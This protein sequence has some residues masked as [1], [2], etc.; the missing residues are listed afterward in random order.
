[1][2]SVLPTDA[3]Y[4]PTP[5]DINFCFPYLAQSLE[6]PQIKLVPFIPRLHA[7]TFF[8]HAREHP[9]DFKHMRFPVPNTLEEMLTW[10]EYNIRRNPENMVFAIMFA[11]EHRQNWSYGAILSLTH[12][13]PERLFAE[14]A[15]GIGFRSHTGRNGAAIGTSLLIRYCMNSPTDSPPG[16]GLRKLGW[17]CHAG[18]FP[19]Q[20]LARSVGFRFESM[21]RWNRTAPSGKE[22]NRR[23]LRK[24]DPLGVPGIDDFYFVLSWDDWEADGRNIV[25]SALS[26][27]FT[28]KKKKGRTPKL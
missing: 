25:E 27:T 16:L 26:R 4:G 15:M 13:D 3:L 1:M 14:V 11:D 19:A 6:S 21:Q 2:P 18:N 24:G 10:F 23:M 9:E 17:T 20:G 7:E 22:N 5:Y 12:C 28:D 8:I